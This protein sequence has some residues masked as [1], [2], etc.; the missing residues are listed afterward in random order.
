MVSPYLN[1]LHKAVRHSQVNS[2]MA[3]V[4]GCVHID[5]QPDEVTSDVQLV[6]GHDNQQWALER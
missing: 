1:D 3:S 2:G 4:V 6:G 5:T